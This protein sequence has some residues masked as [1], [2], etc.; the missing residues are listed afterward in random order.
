MARVTGL[1][2]AHLHLGKYLDLRRMDAV[3][4]L[5]YKAKQCELESPSVRIAAYVGHDW[6]NVQIHGCTSRSSLLFVVQ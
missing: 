3:I 2:I 6:L 5:L 1:A 4:N